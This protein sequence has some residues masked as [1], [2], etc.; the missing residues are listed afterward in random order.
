MAEKSFTGR[1]EFH[2]TDDKILDEE[3]ISFKKVE[4]KKGVRKTETEAG[5]FTPS[6]FHCL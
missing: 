5:H 2:N 6:I 3:I 4:N 1:I